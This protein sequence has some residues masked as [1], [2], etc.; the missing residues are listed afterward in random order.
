ML[1]LDGLPLGT[2]CIIDSHP[3]PFPQD[4]L[5]DLHDFAA[6]VEEYLQSIERHVYTENLKSDLQRTEALFEQT[7]SQAA[8]GMA[9]VSLQGYWLRV[10]PRICEMLQYS[11]RELMDRT[12]QDITYPLDLNTDLEYL[13]QLLKNEIST[14]SM[15]K[16]YFRA[17]GSIVWVQLTVALNRCRTASR[18]ILSRLSSTSASARRRRPTCSPAA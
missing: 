6:V 15:E 11:E 4:K 9:L 13:Q 14:Y 8:V 16:R 2:L 10:N 1:S 5:A 17:D 7:F 12:F 3:H 18:T